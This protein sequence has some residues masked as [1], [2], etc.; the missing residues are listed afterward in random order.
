MKEQTHLF[1]DGF[2]LEDAFQFTRERCAVFQRQLEQQCRFIEENCTA[3]QQEIIC[4]ADQFM[5][6]KMVLCGTMGKP[7][8]VGNPPKWME[9]PLHD[10]EFVWQLNRMEH[11][12][13][14]IRA[15]YLTKEK[16]YALKVLQELENWIDTCPPLEIVL[17]YPTA[18]ERFSSVHPWRSLEI[19]MR[20][21]GSWNQCLEYLICLPE[22]TEQLF[23]KMTESLYRHGRILYE[24]CPVI[25]PKA[26][27]N[28]YLTECLGLLEISGMLSFLTESA[29]WQRHALKE[30]E[31]C[32]CN[33]VTEGGGQVEGCPTYHNECLRGLSHS[34]KMADKY[35]M[36][37]SEHYKELV[38]SMFRYSLYSARPDGT[39]VPWGDSDVSPYV[40]DAAFFLYTAAKDIKPLEYCAALFSKEY[41]L[42]V[43]NNFIWEM[44]Q[45]EELLARLQSPQ[46]GEKA[47]IPSCMWWS[48]ALKQVM[49]RTAWNQHAASLFFACRT[50]VHNDHA[51]IDPN[52]FDYYAQGVPVLVDAGRYNYQE[53]PNRRLFKGGT[54]HNT[55]M[56]NHRDAFAYL[57]TWAYGEQ[58]IGEILTVRQENG[59]SYMCGSH[60]NYFPAIHTRMIQ[61]DQNSLV[62]LDRVDNRSG[63]DQVNLYYNLN[64][65]ETQWEEEAHQICGRIQDKYVSFQYSSNLDCIRLKGRASTQIDQALDTTILNLNSQDASRLF[66]SIFYVGDKTIEIKI[67]NIQDSLETAR[68]DYCLDGTEYQ[69]IWDYKTNT[70]RKE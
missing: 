33:Q 24:V 69:V 63:E 31:R 42:K 25:W 21:Q 30:L 22:F 13:T 6:G 28:H 32:A 39:S 57:G 54:Y 49:V 53:G 23:G 15:Y 37:F 70:L 29:Q 50:P 51:H 43:F 26:D 16:K 52:G 8:F 47:E 10:N 5:E 61:M 55:V 56:L 11:W 35:G 38:S 58:Q 9:N 12:N 48:K 20:A 60:A 66:V 40:Y 68:V 1:K 45:P 14:L 65:A 7:Y 62:I 34:L 18:K 3:Y 4:Q 46:F 2:T 41:L 67:R 27:H 64:T 17:D 19:G 59:Y 44:E 36:V